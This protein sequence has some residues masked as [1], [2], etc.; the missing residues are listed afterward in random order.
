MGINRAEV[1]PWHRKGSAAAP[2]ERSHAI[3][4]LFLPPTASKVWIDLDADKRRLS[5]VRMMTLQTGEE[6]A[7]AIALLVRQA[8]EL[9]E[10]RVA[11]VTAD[12]ALARRV[13][14]HLVRWNIAADDSAG[15]PLSL[16]PAGR[17]FGLLAAL[18]SDGAAPAR[19]IATLAHPL[20]RAGS[21]DERRE[22]L[23]S[24]R[25]FDRALRGPAPAAGLEPLRTVA[26]DAGVAAWW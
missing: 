18:A 8:L 7:Q 13:A 25:T 26:T 5:G 1:R 6:E 4:S 2:A 16:T 21:D 15:R 24:L 19:L 20:V 11:V 10:K 23:I 12:R 17:I 14:Q 9:P 3:S 22:W